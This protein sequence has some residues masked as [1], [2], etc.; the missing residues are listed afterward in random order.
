[1]TWLAA[2]PLTWDLVADVR[3]MLGYD[4]MRHAFGAGTCVAVAAGLVGY[5]VV[6]RNQVF[7]SDALGHV[8]FSGGLAGLV[9]GLPL[10]AGVYASTV[11]VS[12]GIGSLGGRGRGRDVAIGIVFAWVLGLGVLFLSIYTAGTSAADGTVGVAVLFGSILGLQAGP[13]I[14]AAVASLATAAALLAVCRPLLFASLDPDAAAARGVPTRAVSA[15]FL[16]LLALTVAESVQ[17]VGALLIFALL[18]TPAAVAQRLT[19]RPYRALGLSAAISVAFVWV[20]LVLAFVTSLPASSAITGVAF[21]SLLAALAGG[22][23]AHR[24]R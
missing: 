21:A 23:V 11:A 7:A 13:A 6:L 12:L 5:F 8:A 4:F 2:Q 19:A 24:A 3:E 10:L 20:G 1:M 15:V 14:F 22:R 16:V 17:A 18:V 9:A